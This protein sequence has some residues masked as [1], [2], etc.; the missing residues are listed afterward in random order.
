MSRFSSALVV[1]DSPSDRFLVE[2][3]IR[4]LVGVIHKA[5]SVTEAMLKL[6]SADPLPDVVITDLHLHHPTD[7]GIELLRQIKSHP[8]FHAIPVIIITASRP[9]FNAPKA[10]LH[11]GATAHIVKP[12]TAQE[13]F[14]QVRESVSAAISSTE[15]P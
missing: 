6:E 11:L 14:D 9:R 5:A 8:R 15:G 12:D 13:F 4:E 2:Y 3:A 10:S 7:D 1:D